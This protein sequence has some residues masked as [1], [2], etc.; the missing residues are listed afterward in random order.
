[1]RS[2]IGLDKYLVEWRRHS[3]EIAEREIVWLE[4]MINAERKSS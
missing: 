2:A 3:L 1:E 4:N